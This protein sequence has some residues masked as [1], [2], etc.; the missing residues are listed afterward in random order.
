MKNSQ[1][2]FTSI[3]L[4]AAIIAI[5]SIAGYFVLVKEQKKQV[6]PALNLD[7][8]DK[9]NIPKF[10]CTD[11]EFS[12]NITK[13][14]PKEVEFMIYRII[15]CNHWGGEDGYDEERRNDINKAYEE[16]KCSTVEKDQSDFLNKYSENEKVVN[17]IKS[18]NSWEGSCE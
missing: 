3:I 12:K 2:G 7:N 15:Q 18:A 16:N 17:A 9:E 11:I 10:Y 5:L 14:M 4:I 6:E 8:K 1:K 13:N